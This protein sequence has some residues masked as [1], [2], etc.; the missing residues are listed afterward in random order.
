MIDMIWRPQGSA[1]SRPGLLVLDQRGAGLV[2]HPDLRDKR[3]IPLGLSIEWRLPVATTLYNERLYIL[4]VGLGQ[5]WRY[6]PDGDNYSITAGD[7]TVSLPPG[8]NASLAVDLA[9]YS[10]DASLLLAF[11]EGRLGY[12][13]TRGSTVQWGEQDLL[14]E[15]G[16][17]RVPFYNIAAAKLVGRGLNQSIFV[18]D[19]GS[20]RIVQISRGGNILAQYKATDAD[21][22]ELFS[23][24]TDFD[25]PPD[26]PLRMV[27][28]AGNKLYIATLE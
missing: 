27:I 11:Q 17:L 6:F 4:D 25:I 10:E 18:A 1:V 28:T 19:P 7:Q 12:Y 8:V 5:I 22:Q 20:G 13:N 26:P 3:A 23:Q 9:I 16:G 24:I 2:Y 14:A 15:D 21:G